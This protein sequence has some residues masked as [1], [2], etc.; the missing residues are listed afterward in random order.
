MKITISY[1]R[2]RESDAQM[3]AS[4]D[5]AVE[6][7]KVKWDIKLKEAQTMQSEQLLPNPDDPRANDKDTWTLQKRDSP[8]KGKKLK[9]WGKPTLTKTIREDGQEVWTITVEGDTDDALPQK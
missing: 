3:Q 5:K 8:Y 4:L 9:A 7:Q 1:S 2:A 6:S